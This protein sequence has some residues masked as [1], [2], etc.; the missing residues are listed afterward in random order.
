MQLDLSPEEQEVLADA[1]SSY[2]S[3]L[4]YEIGNTDSYDYRSRLK[5]KEE[6]LNRILATLQNADK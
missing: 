3:N 1:L 6:A 4:R 5:A 2:L